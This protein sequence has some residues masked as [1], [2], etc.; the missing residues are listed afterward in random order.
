MPKE[1]WQKNSVDQVFRNAGLWPW[2]EDE[3]VS[4][5]DVACGLSLKSKFIPAK[6]RVGV[7][8]YE[9]YLRHIES[10]VPFVVIKHDVRSLKDI[11]MPES[12]DLVLALD[13]IEHLEKEESLRMIRQCETIA[14]KG[15]ILETPK[16]YIPQN[17]DIWGYGGHKFQTH[18]CGWEP[19]ELRKLG[20][21]VVIRP[22]TMTDVQRH[23]KLKVD[24][25][26]ELMDAIKVF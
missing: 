2:S 10:N 22:Y 18:R 16:G 7:D 15:V 14:K 11:F 17:L 12:F 9:E 1:D 4:I 21:K 19:E 3:I 23:S 20:Y 26:I 6:I 5:L 13:I 24:P 25:N 8:I